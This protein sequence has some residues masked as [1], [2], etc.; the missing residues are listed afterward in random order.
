MGAM[1]SKDQ[2][3]VEVRDRLVDLDSEAV[4]MLC[5]EALKAGMP[6]LEVVTRGLARGMEVVGERF[7]RRE[8]FLPELIMAG[9]VMRE[10]LSIV[11]PHFAGSETQSGP[12]VVIG[13]VQGD[14]HDIG[15]GVVVLLLKALGFQVRD[16][17]FDVPAERFVEAVKEGGVRILAMS[18]LLTATMP[19]MERV[20]DQ[21]EK[22]GLRDHVKVIIGGAPITKAFGESIGVDYATNDAV[23]GVN[24]CKKWAAE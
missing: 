6:P 4:K 11:G 8:Y 1:K 17:G 20:V 24:M 14:M 5:R 7:E 16:L 13:T 10:G 2:I 22:E 23:E 19:E 21:L 3:L 18:A 9:E 12:M 15:K